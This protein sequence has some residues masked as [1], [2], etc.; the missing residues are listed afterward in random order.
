MG[1]DG[2]RGVLPLETTEAPVLLKVQSCQAGL[3]QKIGNYLKHNKQL[4][5]QLC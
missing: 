5:I 3:R 1:W 4:R 2:M